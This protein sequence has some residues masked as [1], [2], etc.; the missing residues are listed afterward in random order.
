M[1]KF[2]ETKNHPRLK[3]EEIEKPNRQTTGNDIASVIKNLP[4]NK[5]SGPKGFPG[6]F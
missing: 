3:Q 2:L 4:T 5:S 1:N 6:K